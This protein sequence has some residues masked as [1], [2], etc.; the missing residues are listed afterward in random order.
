MLL[1]GPESRR[2][3]RDDLRGYDWEG[4]RWEGCGR[5]EER[6]SLSLFS[7]NTGKA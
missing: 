2:W 6:E 7:S 4:K 3:G 5:L 1:D